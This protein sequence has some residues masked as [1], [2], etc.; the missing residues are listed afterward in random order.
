MDHSGMVHALEQTRRL[1]RPG[2]I[3]MDIHPVQEA[4]LTEV[5]QR[6]RVLFAEPSLAYDYDE[7][8]HQAE[9]ALARCVRRRIFVKE[10]G[11]EIDFLTYGSSVLELRD[12]LKEANSF[13]ES[14]IDE[15]DEAREAEFY[16]RVEG[17]MKAAGEGVEVAVHERARITRLSP[18]P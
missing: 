17:I 10:R 8:I 12:F 13:H 4:P 15:A 6:G 2:G 18:V 5:H 14:S 1:L 7:D 16:D 11:R 3:L 9:R